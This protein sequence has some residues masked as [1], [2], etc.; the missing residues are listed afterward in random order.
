MFESQK[1][2]RQYLEFYGVADFGAARQH[3]ACHD[4]ALPSDAKACISSTLECTKVFDST[5][6]LYLDIRQ[7]WED[8]DF[9]TMPVMTVTCPDGKEQ[10]SDH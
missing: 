4:C 6:C 3:C 1:S 10:S 9:S 2:R 5:L 7:L 8:L